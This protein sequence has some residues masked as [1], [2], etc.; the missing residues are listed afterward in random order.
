MDGVLPGPAKQRSI[1]W[2]SFFFIFVVL[3]AA[4][5]LFQSPFFLITNIEVRG[6]SMLTASEI[7]EVS[8]IVTGVNIFKADLKTA[9]DRVKMLPLVKNVEAGRKYPGTVVIMVQER[10]PVALVVVERDFVELDADGYYLRR[11]KISAAGLPVITGVPVKSAGPGKR[12]EGSGLDTALQVV[13]Q[14]P[15]GLCEVLSEVHVAGDGRVTLYTMDGVECR[16]G[17]PENVDSKGS[18]ILQVLDNLRNQ[19]AKSIEYV[20]FSIISSPVVKYRE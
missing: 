7:T 13:E 8:G 10:T 1:Y 18:Y 4:Y 19:N 12:V 9:M 15:A 3:L 16:L 11:G 2:Q 20:D 17:L 6:N 5:V 14:L